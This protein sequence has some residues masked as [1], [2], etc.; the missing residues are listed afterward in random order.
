M[1]RNITVT[2][3]I[4]S[5]S[6]LI[7]I[8]AGCGKSNADENLV[9][10]NVEDVNIKVEVLKPASYSEF[11]SVTGS[12][13]ANEDVMISPEEGGVVKEWFVEKGQV[14]KKGQMLCVLNDDLIQSNYDA[15]QAQYNMSQINFEMQSKVFQ[16]KA[17]SELQFKNAQYARDAAKAQA[18]MMKVRLERT[19]I[20]SP[21]DGIFNDRYKNAG[22]FAPPMVPLA[23]V[24]NLE[25]IKA[26]AEISEKYAGAVKVGNSAIVVPDAYPDDSLKAQ[27]IFVGAS[28]SSSNR[29]L[30]L[31]LALSNPR[32]RLKP[33]MIVRISIINIIRHNALLVEESILQE[34]DRNKTV[35]YVEKNG[36]V[37]ERIVQLGGRHGT[38]R[39]VIKGLKAGEH[40]VVSGFQK[41]VH[42]QTV[43]VIE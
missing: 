19:R 30:P 11:I 37:E 17:I 21:I 42:G 5:V 32:F 9:Q 16:E 15:A 25:S 10:Q 18:T 40:I 28:V 4:L 7:T 31:E 13:K 3:I 8:F 1:K 38:K 24:V 12:I 26:G 2:S 6:F 36:K 20:K 29:T 33:E 27:I 14:V 43:R 23:H 22:E 39:E 41:L 34:V 35:V